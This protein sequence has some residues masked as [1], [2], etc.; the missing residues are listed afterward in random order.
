MSDETDDLSEEEVEL[1][2]VSD[3]TTALADLKPADKATRDRLA[4]AVEALM[5]K[6]PSDL[7]TIPDE[8]L[9]ALD[10]VAQ[11][12]RLYVGA[13]LR[14]WTFL[15]RKAESFD[16]EKEQARLGLGLMKHVEGSKTLAFN[17]GRT[18]DDKKLASEV[19][20]L[21]KSL[22]DIMTEKHKILEA[23]II[24]ADTP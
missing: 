12:R 15:A 7:T 3:L 5:A 23:K 18:K 10:T 6:I 9:M 22:Q 19:D 13:L 21:R 8:E 16:E 24:D 4:L 1:D 11:A 20:Q 14:M 17:F 2:V